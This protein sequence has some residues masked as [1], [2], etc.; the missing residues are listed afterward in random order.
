MGLDVYVMPLWRFKVGDFQP[1]IQTAI[2]VRPKI[3]TVDGINEQP[4]RVGWFRRW[5][6]RRQVAAIRKTVEA[7]NRHSITWADDGGVVYSAQSRGFE[8]LRAYAKWLDCQKQFPEFDPPPEG[9]YYK[10]PAMAAE[11]GRLSCPHLVEHDCYLGYFLPCEFER[12]VRVEPYLIFGNWPASR[13]V[14][15]TPRLLRELD[16]IAAALQLS[17]G[18]DYPADHPL[19]AVKGAFLQLRKV[20]Q[21]GCRRGLPIIFQG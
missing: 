1:P 8:A 2:G 9:N 21:L 16:F 10:H 11:V 5:R 14:G 4:T 17:A 19:V 3:V 20:A 18:C 12:M 13:P 6:A 15:S 7:A